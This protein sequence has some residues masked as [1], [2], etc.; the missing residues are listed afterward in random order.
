MEGIPAEGILDGGRIV[1]VAG[2]KSLD[3]AVA[4]LCYNG[5][6]VQSVP[7]G[8]TFGRAVREGGTHPNCFTSAE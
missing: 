8:A 1:A 3:L 7:Y 5:K 6:D 4:P 2:E